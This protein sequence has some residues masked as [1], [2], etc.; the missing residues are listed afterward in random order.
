VVTAVA[1]WIEAQLSPDAELAKRPSLLGG[2]GHPGIEVFR[3]IDSVVLSGT[4]W[5]ERDDVFLS[6]ALSQGHVKSTGIFLWHEVAD[7]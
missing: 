5:G 6:R 3:L 4:G 2:L 7:V 1:A